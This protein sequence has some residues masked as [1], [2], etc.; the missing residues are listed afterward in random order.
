MSDEDQKRREEI[1]AETRKDLLTRQLSN[2]EKFDGAVLTL[3]TAALG[4]SLTFIK[5]IVPLNKV[6]DIYLLKISWWLFGF[7]ILSTMLSFVASQLG[8]STQLKYAEEYYLN[9]KNEYLAKTNIP[10]RITD[11]FNY[12]AAFFFVVALVFTIVFVSTNLRGD[13]IMANKKTS[14]ETNV[15]LREGAPVPNMQPITGG[16]TE[17]K[18]APIPNMQPVPSG[19]Q[20]QTGGS[21]STQKPQQSQS[22]GGQNKK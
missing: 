6:Q 5:D 7:A 15:T 14:K 2:S 13:Q 8:I 12:A 20:T 11:G 4:V 10:A 19:G 9:K 1:Y 17:K 18:G 16:G 22:D 21:T 3:S